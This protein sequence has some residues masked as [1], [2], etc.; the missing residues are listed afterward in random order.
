MTEGAYPSSLLLSRS[1]QAE[2]LRL[3]LDPVSRVEQE[4]ARY[5][6]RYRCSWWTSVIE[7][8]KKRFVFLLVFN[9]IG[10]L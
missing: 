3:F 9:Y 7:I 2:A 5:Y 10:C 8:R 1:M 6:D 4:F